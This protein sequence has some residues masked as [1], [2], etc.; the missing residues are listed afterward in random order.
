MKEAFGSHTQLCH[1]WAQQTQPAGHTKNLY[2]L[3]FTDLYSYGG[4]YLAAK[5]HT[6]KQGQ[7]YALIRSDSYSN[8]TS[9]HLNHAARAVRGLMEYWYVPNVEKIDSVENFN[10]FNDRVINEVDETLRATKVRYKEDIQHYL[11]SIDDMVNDANEFFKFAD[12]PLIS[13]PQDILDLVREH[14]EYRLKR[15]EELNTPEHRAKLEADK[16]KREER[17]AE[18]EREKKALEIQ[19]WRDGKRS[20]IYGRSFYD[21]LRVQGNEV[22][23][24]SGASVPLSHALRLLSMIEKGTVRAGERIGHFTYESSTDSEW[25]DDKIIKIGCHKIKLSEAQS[26]LAPY[27]EQELKIAE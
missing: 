10:H 7:P 17:K 24:T 12:L 8:S 14:L 18:K 22:K 26:V 23:T 16:I 3:N 11:N 4:H 21:L 1:V 15:Y 25:E 9:K 6:T 27:R 20:V 19:E 5:I 2:F 13:V